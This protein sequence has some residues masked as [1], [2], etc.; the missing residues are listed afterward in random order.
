MSE[1]KEIEE[2]KQLVAMY[3]GEGEDEI[4]EEAEYKKLAAIESGSRT[5]VQREHL[6]SLARVLMWKLDWHKRFK[7][8]KERLDDMGH[9]ITE[10]MHGR[11][12]SEPTLVKIA[13]V[14]LRN[15]EEEVTKLIEEEVK[16]H[17]TSKLQGIPYKGST[18]S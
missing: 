8:A 7:A 10:H 6:R 13:E 3:Q 9:L 18:S 12:T 17:L 14:I 11:E 2:L 15:E 1:P 5:P 16:C 4:P